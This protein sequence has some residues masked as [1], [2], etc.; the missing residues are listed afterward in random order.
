MWPELN[1]ARDRPTIAALHLLTQIVGKVPAALVPWRNHGWHVALHMTPR[2]MRTEPIHAREGTFELMIDLV[3]HVVRLDDV[4][5]QRS[6]PL[7]AMHV[8]EFHAGV[9]R[10]LD[11]AGYA[12]RLNGAPNEIESAI[13][14]A[15]DCESRVYDRDSAERLCAALNAAHRVFQLFRSAYLGKVSPVHFF[16]GSFD[17]AVTRFS[18]RTA[19]RHPG[20][21]PNLP[22]AITREAYSHE[23]SSAGF[24]PGSA[25]SRG[26]PFFYSYGYPVPDGFADA[27][28]EPA[29]A[30][31]DSE[32]GEFMLPY[33]AVRSAA[34]PD[35]AL[36]AFL[37]TTYDAA[38]DLGRWD[39][40]A[41]ECGYGRPRI[42]RVV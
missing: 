34:N 9:L 2:G 6:I 29:E 28:V 13:P 32:L 21:I 10:M 30:R 20:G 8:A 24:W 15:Q 27:K 4:R 41:L 25:A 3:S 19:P 17:L 38:A 37:Q 36:L 18:G 22:D 7:A 16:W 26:E 40:A 14:F 33:A 35:A 1:E 11:E 5:G 39:R 42:P 23:V 31:F 12:L